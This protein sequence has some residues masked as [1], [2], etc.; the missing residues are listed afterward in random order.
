MYKTNPLHESEK[1]TP[2]PNKNVKS[3]DDRRREETQRRRFHHHT[4]PVTHHVGELE[5]QERK[6]EERSGS[7]K[8]EWSWATRPHGLLFIA[9]A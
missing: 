9:A 2:T 5:L 1:G 6:E 4:V 3:K 8:T 7:P